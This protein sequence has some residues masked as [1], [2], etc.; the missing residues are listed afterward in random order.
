MKTT[1][2][3]VN[4]CWLTAVVRSDATDQTS[5]R[6]KAAPQE[7][8]YLRELAD[9]ERELDFEDDES[10]IIGGSLASVGE[11]EW[12]T[13][14]YGCGATLVHKDVILTGT[15]CIPHAALLLS[16]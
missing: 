13:Q 8:S 5:L 3:I 15:F 4:L 16:L 12:F 10:R 9:I 6:G 1:L 14:G 11:F 7:S 2:A